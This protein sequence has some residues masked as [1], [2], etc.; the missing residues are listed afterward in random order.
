MSIGVHP[1]IVRNMD[2]LRKF[3]KNT[4]IHGDQSWHDVSDEYIQRNF[5]PKPFPCLVTY[6]LK[7][8]EE[9]GTGE[10]KTRSFPNY[11]TVN[12]LKFELEYLQAEV[13][14]VSEAIELLTK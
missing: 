12:E 1:T 5:E 3:L 2:G 10:M 13:K 4:G 7:E 8:Y 6:G 14:L 9:W 11:T